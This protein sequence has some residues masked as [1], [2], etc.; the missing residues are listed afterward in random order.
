MPSWAMFARH[1]KNF[2]V[3]H[4]E[5]R[6]AENEA[7]PAITLDDVTGVTFDHA[8]LQRAAGIPAFRLK[9][10]QGFVIQASPGFAD[11]NRS[12]KSVDEML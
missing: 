3:H 4:V 9:G 6:F 2:D 10:V 8:K 7:R 12:N 1:V 11:T 5:F